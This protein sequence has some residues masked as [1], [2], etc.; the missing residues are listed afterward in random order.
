MIVF[1]QN[2]Q[3]TAVYVSLVGLVS[4]PFASLLGI[5]FKFI[6]VAQ[7]LIMI[8]YLKNDLPLNLKNMLDFLKNYELSYLLPSF[9]ENSN[10]NQ[11]K[12]GRFAQNNLSSLFLDNAFTLVMISIIIPWFLLLILMIIKKNFDFFP[13]IFKKLRQPLDK[14]ENLLKFNLILSFFCNSTQE[15]SLFIA[16]QL[17]FISFN[18]SVTII[19]F[20]FC[21]LIFLIHFLVLFWLF[22]I[23]KQILSKEKAAI[24]K[25]YEAVFEDLCI[26][27][28]TALVFPIVKMF[29]KFL[30]SFLIV[31][32]YS[33]LSILVILLCILTVTMYLYIRIVQPYKYQFKNIVSELTEFLQ[34]CLYSLLFL[35]HNSTLASLDE[36]ALYIGYISIFIMI[37]I[38]LIN[39]IMMMADFVILAVNFIKLRRKKKGKQMIEFNDLSLEIL[40]KNEIIKEVPCQNDKKQFRDAETQCEVFEEKMKKPN[41]SEI[42]S[43]AFFQENRSNSNL[44]QNS[45][46]GTSDIFQHSPNINNQNSENILSEKEIVPPHKSTILVL[47]NESDKE[48]ID[49]D[50]SNRKFI[51]DA[52]KLLKLNNDEKNFYFRNYFSK[53]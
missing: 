41:F 28:K 38:I 11:L 51:D 10:D 15:I 24:P 33:Y 4:L 30:L 34:C 42:K 44:M 48:K 29:R 40:K 23:T 20:L 16:L 52:E 13:S 49:L 43:D 17:N 27:R 12:T 22:K 37:I 7:E 5:F 32:L 8:L 46:K 25:E 53:D 47:K 14:F 1:I 6:E 31:F 9:F 50:E 35:Y 26:E 21:I 2:A 18:N 45:R 19:S 36:T 39:F 3:T